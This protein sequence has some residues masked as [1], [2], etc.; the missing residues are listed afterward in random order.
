M[1]RYLQLT[2]VI[3]PKHTANAHRVPLMRAKVSAGSPPSCHAKIAA[4]KYNTPTHSPAAT[5]RSQY[6]RLNPC[7]SK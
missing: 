1:K 2:T 6:V 5:N 7:T 4:K 3:A